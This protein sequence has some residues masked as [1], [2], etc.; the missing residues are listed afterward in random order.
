MIER[1]FVWIGGALFAA[2]LAF[3]AYSFLV[4]WSRSAPAVDFAAVATDLLL[5]TI[6]AAH[7]SVLAR[8]RVKRRLA[9]L[10]SDRL[11]RSTYVWTA[12]LLLIAVCAM[13]RPIGG[14]LFAVDG[15]RAIAAASV[16]L[17]GIGLIAG[18]V[19]RIDPLELAG[20]RAAPRTEPLE[21]GG[22]YRL[23][24]HPVYLGWMLAAFGA[25]HMTGDRLAFAAVSSLYLLVA[26]P[27]EE[28]SLMRAFPDEY[29]AYK[30]RV[31]WRVVPFVF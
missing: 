30:A 11:I 28:R 8:E 1:G 6:F 21:T 29:E 9:A 25:G 5:F 17:I 13:W 12:S 31:R 27:W 18:A 10:V 16:Q 19:A 20:I 2:A 24:R 22:P 14:D 3:C 26:I 7:H 15:W 23:V 4:T